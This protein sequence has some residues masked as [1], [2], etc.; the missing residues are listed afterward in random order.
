[1]RAKTLVELESVLD[2]RRPAE[3]FDMGLFSRTETPL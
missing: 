1:M 3:E 2:E